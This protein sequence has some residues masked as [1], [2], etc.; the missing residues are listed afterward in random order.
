MFMNNFEFKVNDVKRDKSA[1]YIIISLS[2]M[3]KDL[4]FV[5]VYGPNR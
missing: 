2:A 3:G 5:N 4:I 1:N